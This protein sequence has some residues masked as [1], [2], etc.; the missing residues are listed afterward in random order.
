CDTGNAM[1]N[2][3]RT[4][5][6]ARIERS[7]DMVCFYIKGDGFLYHMVRI[8]VGTLLKVAS[9]KMQPEQIR[10]IIKSKD[11]KLAGMTVPPQGLYLNEVFY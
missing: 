1:E 11:R 8:I 9:N 3:T 2:Q 4:I 7:G 10:T 6:H 5:V